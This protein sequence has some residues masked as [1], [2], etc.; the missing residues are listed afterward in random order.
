MSDKPRH[1]G[2]IMDGNRRWARRQRRPILEGHYAG[3]Q[4]AER[5]IRHAFEKGIGYVTIFAFSAENWQR[6]QEEVSYLLSLFC[7]A[8]EDNLS[9]LREEGVCI[10][11]I[12]DTQQFPPDIQSQIDILEES[13]DGDTKKNTLTIC[14]GYSGRDEILHAVKKMLSDGASS[15]S[16]CEEDFSK[17]LYTGDMP[18][19]DLIIRTSGEKRLSGFLLWQSAYAELYFT[20]ILWPDFSPSDFDDALEE[21]AQ[22]K[23]R[24]G[25]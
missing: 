3:L 16:I 17:A 2:I 4:T 22:R 1:V 24:F 8:F 12:G 25:K 10:R 20:D 11:F 14:F 5:I 23:R 6:G 18:D 19:P 13:L 21:F 9:T 15:S 7:A